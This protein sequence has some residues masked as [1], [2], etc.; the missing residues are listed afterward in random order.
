MLA[1]LEELLEV[2]HKRNTNIKNLRNNDKIYIHIV[3]SEYYK[4][5]KYLLE[6]S[7]ITTSEC[8]FNNSKEQHLFS[9]VNGACELIGKGWE[10][11][12]IPIIEKKKTFISGFFSKLFS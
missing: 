6:K 8:I 1:R 11:E 5:I 2:C 3:C 10:K 12:A 4:N 9:A 7:K